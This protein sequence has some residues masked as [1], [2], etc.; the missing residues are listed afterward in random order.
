MMSKQLKRKRRTS[1][2]SSLMPMTAER[3]GATSTSSKVLP[4]AVML[5]N[6]RVSCA[7]H[8]NV[9]EADGRA[10]VPGSPLVDKLALLLLLDQ[11]ANLGPGARLGDL[12]DDVWKSS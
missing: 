10:D 12:L 9:D 8:E 5:Q 3:P 4:E 2:V 6:R 7:L 1:S 11:R